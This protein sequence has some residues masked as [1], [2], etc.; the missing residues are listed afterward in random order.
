M[1]RVNASGAGGLGRA[2][3]GASR[4]A[5][6]LPR[7]IAADVALPAAD[8]VLD[9]VRSERGSLTLSNARMRLDVDTDV[10]GSNAGAALELS[11][12]PRAAWGLASGAK[13]HTIRPRRGR[14]LK[15]DSGR[16]AQTVQ[17][18]GTRRRPLWRNATR[19]A[20]TTIRRAADQSARAN[21]PFRQ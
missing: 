7:T 12:S 11:A 20:Q 10:S 5:Q 1:I 15:L 19:T 2:L 13:A 14:V 8:A 3:A 21:N 4:R 9:A 6:Q 16:Y 18:P 17:H